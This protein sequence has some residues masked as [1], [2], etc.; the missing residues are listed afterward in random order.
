VL[1]SRNGQIASARLS[2]CD[3]WIRAL[4]REK[5]Q[6]FD[7]VVRRWETSYAIMSIALDDAFALRARGKLICARQQVCVSSNLS[8]RLA[9]ALVAFCEVAAQRGRRIDNVPAVE[10]M[11]TEFF[12]SEAGQSAASWNNILHH[13]LFVGRFRFLHKL[14]LLASTIEE[15]QRQFAAAA[16]DLSGA[17]SHRPLDS[18][19]ALDCLHYDF[20]TCLR[21]MEILVKSFLRAL[22]AEQVEAFAR[23][24]ETP[25]AGPV[26]PLLD[27]WSRPAS[28]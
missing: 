1:F 12:R 8:S 25:L 18:W 24:L 16:D 5:N 22:P 26:K 7:C 17:L 20:N 23:E 15:I 19:K 10:P 21:E 2:V 28:A 27:A 6:V 11:R 3:D 13:V 14:R 9:K 4:P